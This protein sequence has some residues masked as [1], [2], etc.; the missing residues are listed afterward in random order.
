MLDHLFWI[1]TGVFLFAAQFGFN[2]ARQVEFQA[3]PGALVRL[4][5]PCG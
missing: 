1:A 5:G 3:D 4:T 2:G